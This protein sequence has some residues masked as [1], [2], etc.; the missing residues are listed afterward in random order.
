MTSGKG[1]SHWFWKLLWRVTLLILLTLALLTFE[2]FLIHQRVL[3]PQTLVWTVLLISAMYSVLFLYA[4][5][6]PLMKFTSTKRQESLEDT[7]AR[8]TSGEFRAAPDEVLLFRY[9]GWWDKQ[10]QLTDKGRAALELVAG[11]RATR[12]PK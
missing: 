5:G 6:R 1:G 7:F 9:Q 4:V 11:R 8:V 3:P 12:R 10:H 2:L